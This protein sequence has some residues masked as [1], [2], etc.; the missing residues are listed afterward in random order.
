M[1][2]IFWY[3]VS[4]SGGGSSQLSASFG[5]S[6]TSCAAMSKAELLSVICRALS[7]AAQPHARVRPGV[8]AGPF[9]P[10]LLSHSHRFS[11]VSGSGQAAQAAPLPPV[12]HMAA[13]PAPEPRG[14]AAVCR[15][16]GSSKGRFARSPSHRHCDCV[17]EGH[18]RGTGTRIH[19]MES[20]PP[21][22]RPIGTLT[23]RAHLVPCGQEA[24]PGPWSSLLA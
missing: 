12:P 4:S 3:T 22:G 6:Q 5:G 19:Y 23:A 16:A 15:G 8:W 2:L 9:E 11:A 21:Q 14:C 20:K 10:S 7:H 1:H 13:E 17:P 18:L 24:T